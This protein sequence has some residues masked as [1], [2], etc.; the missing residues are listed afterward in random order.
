[1]IFKFGDTAWTYWGIEPKAG[2]FY[3]FFPLLTDNE[4][5]MM[6]LHLITFAEAKKKKQKKR[7]HR[8][9]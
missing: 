4:R 8:A 6:R 9:A 5:E 7:T 3:I 2:P 1:M